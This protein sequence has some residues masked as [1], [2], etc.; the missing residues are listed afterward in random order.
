MVV[1]EIAVLR[2]DF[3]INTLN[4]DSNEQFSARYMKQVSHLKKHRYFP[5]V[6]QK[7]S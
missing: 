4:G 1:K 7:S 3:V 2:P 6:L 5:P